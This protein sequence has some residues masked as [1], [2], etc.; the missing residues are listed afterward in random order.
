MG[1]A[2]DPTRG[3]LH[4]SYLALH[5][6][7]LHP[8]GEDGWHT[9]IPLKGAA[10]DPAQYPLWAVGQNAENGEGNN[11]DNDAGNDGA[12]QGE[13]P[14]GRGA[15]GRQREQ[16]NRG[17]CSDDEDDNDDPDG[18]NDPDVDPEARDKKT[19]TVTALEW[20]LSRARGHSYFVG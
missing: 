8:N 5:Y 6:P 19:K 4:S 1:Q 9:S 7:L 12:A 13:R 18:D 2:Q 10:W 20:I 16:R 3:E 14:S 15:Q 17:D 11:G